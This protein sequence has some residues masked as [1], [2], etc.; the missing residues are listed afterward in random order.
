MLKIKNMMSIKSAGSGVVTTE[1]SAKHV[2]T[3]L[4][5]QNQQLAEELHKT[6]IR[7]IEKR[8][9][10]TSFKDN[11]WGADLADIQL[12]SKYNKGIRFL[13]CAVDI[14]S[15]YA[16]VVPIKDKKG[17]SIVTA[18][19]GILNRSN[20]KPN[21]I[22]VDK[23]SEFYNA[24]FK[25]WLRHNDIVCIQQIMKENLSLLRDLLER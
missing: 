25:K 11:I 9:V 16:L 22:W 19:Q 14:F 10:H 1:P 2:N 4:A 18:F 12:L 15:K 17:V 6:I 13:L 24:S 8:K 21:K 20:R 7:K 3:K 5:P 23:S